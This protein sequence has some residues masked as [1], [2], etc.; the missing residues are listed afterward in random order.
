[1]GAESRATAGNGCDGHFVANLESPKNLFLFEGVRW[2]LLKKNFNAED[3]EDAENAENAENAEFT[4][5]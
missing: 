2:R 5:V 1:M 3:A 4:Q